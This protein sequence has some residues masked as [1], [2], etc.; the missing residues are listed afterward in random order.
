[1][2]SAVLAY[3]P[4]AANWDWSNQTVSFKRGNK[5]IVGQC[6]WWA[7]E[8]RLAMGRALPSEALGDGGS[9]GNYLSKRWQYTVNDSPEVGAVA[10]SAHHVTVVE[11][12]NYNSTGNIDSIVIS[13]MNNRGPYYVD[14]RTIPA[15]NIGD[16]WYIH[17]PR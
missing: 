9:W 5:M 7:W 1:M 11:K 6:T 15:A 16:F 3:I 10:E 2:S 17:N 12:V 8:R 13:E 14:L 4:Q